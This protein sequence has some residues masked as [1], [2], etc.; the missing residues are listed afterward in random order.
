MSSGR[1]ATDSS[2]ISG[3]SLAYGPL[4]SSSAIEQ[5]TDAQGVTGG[6]AAVASGGRVDSAS[7]NTEPWPGWLDDIRPAGAARRW[8]VARPGHLLVAAACCLWAAGCGQEPPLTQADAEAPAAAAAS[9]AAT[10][11]RA[12]DALTSRTQAALGC[13]F[14]G[15]AFSRT[16]EPYRR[17]LDGLD[18]AAS[19]AHL[20][21]LLEAEDNRRRHLGAAGLL[22]RGEAYRTDRDLAARVLAVAKGERDPSVSRLL[23]AVVARLD[24][25]DDETT[26]TLMQELLSTHPDAALRAGLVGDVLPVQGSDWFEPTRRAAT[27]DAS[28]DV[29]LAA[30]SAFWIGGAERAGEVCALWADHLGDRDRRIAE[31]ASYLVAFWGH[32]EGSSYDALLAEAERRAAAGTMTRAWFASVEALHAAKTAGAD[33]RSAVLAVART[34]ASVVANGWGAR[35]RAIELVRR[36]ADD[37]EAFASRFLDD[38]GAQAADPGAAPE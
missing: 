30:L 19:D 12:A 4:D 18:G 37:G 23:G 10:A 13:D 35:S 36:E 7:Y 9:A 28:A 3:T 15:A 21:E 8:W 11:E 20:V 34:T 24:T 1:L 25:K 6:L 33:H 22:R 2:T 26:A 27:S 31:K 38:D 16:C 5:L 32:C 29:R 14:S 17:W